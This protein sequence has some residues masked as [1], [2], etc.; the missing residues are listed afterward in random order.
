MTTA[1]LLVVKAGERVA[2]KAA[3][4]FGRMDPTGVA[5]T[6]IAMSVVF[7]SLILLYLT[8]KYVAKLYNIDLKKRF[9]KSRQQTEITEELEEIS[10]ETL[11]AI[12]LALH[13]YHEQLQGLE[14]AVMTFKNASKTYSPW[15]SKIYGLRR[16]PNH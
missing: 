8:F 13:L 2:G 4:E 10:G 5:M 9:R 12:S 16:T 7:I 14:D 1:T 15:S 6:I 11:V 3:E